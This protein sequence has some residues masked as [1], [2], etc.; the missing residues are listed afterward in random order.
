MGKPVDVM[1][2]CFLHGFGTRDSPRLTRR[3][4]DSN[5]K[6]V[7]KKMSPAITKPLR[8]TSPLDDCKLSHQGIDKANKR[9]TL[10]QLYSIMQSQEY[11]IGGGDGIE[12]I[13]GSVTK[14]GMQRIFN[15]MHL[16]CQF[17][18]NSILVDIGA[19][20]GR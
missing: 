9:D 18:T 7:N 2:C 15:L 4:F 13:Y 14:K 10:D 11:R 19:G 16:L 8:F 12:G 5:I 3:L 6:Q 1:H 20:L 17:D